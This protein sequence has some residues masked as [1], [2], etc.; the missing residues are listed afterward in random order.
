[1]DKYIG[2]AIMALFPVSADDVVQG[3]IAM[4]KKLDDYNQNRQLNGYKTIKIGIGLNTGKLMLGTIGG[5]NRMDG[6]VISDTVNLASRVECLTKRY[7]SP[8]LITMQ[9]YEK[10]INPSKYKIRLIDAIKVKGKSEDITVYEVFDMDSPEKQ[11][12]KN[13]TQYEFK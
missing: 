2:D 8:L 7:D 11:I 3:A 12:L 4:L 1:M 13:E 5:K 10:L 6:T 9:T